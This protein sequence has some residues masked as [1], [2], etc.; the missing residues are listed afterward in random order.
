VRVGTGRVPFCRRGIR[1][2][3][4]SGPGDRGHIARNVPSVTATVARTGGSGVAGIR[5]GSG[6]SCSG[7]SC[8]GLSCSD[9]PCSDLP[10]SDLHR[11][12]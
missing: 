1:R 4:T 7:L 8:S 12:S 9:L 3:G 2:N 10:R 5:A 11:T 6:L